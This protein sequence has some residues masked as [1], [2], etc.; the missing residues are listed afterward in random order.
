MSMA[1]GTVKWFKADIGYGFITGEDGNDVYVH[2]SSIQ[3]SGF[4]T[5]DKG[6]Q[7]EYDVKQTDRGPQ[8]ANVVKL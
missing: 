6:Q 2:Y 7:V 8:A 4:K 1:V 5:L 3:G